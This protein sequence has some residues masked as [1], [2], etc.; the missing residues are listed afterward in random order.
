VLILPEHDQPFRIEADASKY[1]IGGVLSQFRNGSWRPVSYFSKHLSKTEMNYSASERE[2]LAIVLSV[3]RFKQY[4]YGREFLILTDHMPLKFLLTADVPDARLARLM[5]RL[6]IYTYTIEYRA[7]KSHGNAD[8]LSRMLDENQCVSSSFDDSQTV[9]INA[10]RLCGSNNDEQLLDPTI[11]CIYDMKIQSRVSGIR[12]ELTL[13]L[14]TPEMSEKELKSLYSQW[15]RLIIIGHNLYRE[16][17]D[18]D[19]IFYQ[20][21]VPRLQR[22]SVM[23]QAHDSVCSGHMG[24]EKTISRVVTKLYWYRQLSDIKEYVR[25]CPLCQQIKSLPKDKAKLTPIRTSRPS[26]LWT[27]DLMGPLPRSN[28]G[29]LYVL[30]VVDHFT[31]WV[32]LFAMESIT[33]AELAK[34]LMLVFYRHGIPDTILSDQ[35]TNYQAA[36]LAELYELLDIHKVRTSPYHPQCDGLTERFNRTLQAMLTSYI[37]ENQKNWDELLPTLAFAYNTA[38]NA[39]TKMTPFELVYGRTPKVPLDLIYPQLKLELFLS[40]EGYANQVQSA[41]HS[42]FDLVIKNRNLSMDKNKLLYDRNVRAASFDLTDLVW[43]LDTTTTTGKTSKLSRRW[44]G[45][46]QILARVNS[47]TYEVKPKYSKG[48]KLIVNQCRL[49]KCFTRDYENVTGQALGVVGDNPQVKN[50]RKRKLITDTSNPSPP[51]ATPESPTPWPFGSF[52]E[53]DEE[54]LMPRDVILSPVD[55]VIK[56]S[57]PIESCPAVPET[58]SRTDTVGHMR[59]EDLE[60]VTVDEVYQ[61]NNYYEAQLANAPVGTRPKSTRFR[62][63]RSFLGVNKPLTGHN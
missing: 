50:K 55:E 19:D 14:I 62:K 3:E 7:G 6:L 45:P 46:Y 10:L 31:K 27:T 41:L 36:L 37:D 42:A 40:K 44:K 9:V 56:A 13:E 5:N 52:F 23:K 30:V 25:S 63:E 58:V 43:V 38:V 49:S 47:N 22:Q 8:A 18:G 26:E 34:R 4:V 33:S 39:T 59:F 16:Y 11:K 17:V 12:P 32:E 54:I 48:K 21:I 2:M 57:D 28:G 15:S 20:Y 53:V 24:R 35:G 60:D 61:P 1:G 51:Q 29:N